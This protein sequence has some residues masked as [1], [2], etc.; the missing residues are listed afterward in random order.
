MAVVIGADF[1]FNPVASV[2]DLRS[3][4][5]I[6]RMYRLF[7]PFLDLPG[8][9]I[10]VSFGEGSGVAEGASSRNCYP[11]GAVL[12]DADDVTAGSEIASELD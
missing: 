5:P 9:P 11:D 1:K 8:D 3:I 2:Q 4:L 6:G 10:D 7:P 12:L